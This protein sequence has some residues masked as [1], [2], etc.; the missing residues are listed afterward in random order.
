MIGWQAEHL[1][2]LN[3]RVPFEEKHVE[4][5]SA[6]HLKRYTLSPRLYRL[7]LP[8]TTEPGRSVIYLGRPTSEKE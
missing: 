1:V 3:D 8:S 5:C 7:L 2:V 6:L 4:R